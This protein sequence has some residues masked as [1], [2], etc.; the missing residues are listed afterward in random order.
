MCFWILSV[1]EGWEVEGKGRRGLV[2]YIVTGHQL[3]SSIRF[4]HDFPFLKQQQQQQQRRRLIKQSDG[5]YTL[6]SLESISL[7]EV[8]STL[9]LMFTFPPKGLR[10]HLAHCV[11]L[12]SPSL[13]PFF[14]TCCWLNL[15]AV[16]LLLKSTLVAPCYSLSR[17]RY[18]R[19]LHLNIFNLIH[20]PLHWQFQWTWVYV[21]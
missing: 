2:R 1:F 9:V 3:P 19:N 4:G 5:W 10:H 15:E 14:S 11:S 20:S 21:Y 17:R 13:F 12:V 16:M 7:Q 8:L 6:C 18:L